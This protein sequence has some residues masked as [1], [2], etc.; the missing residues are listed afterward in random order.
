MGLCESYV[1]IKTFEV[2]ISKY[3]FSFIIQKY[4]LSFSTKNISDFCHFS[5]V[6]A[7]RAIQTWEEENNCLD[8]ICV[9]F[10]N[11]LNKFHVRLD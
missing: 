11:T 7:M 2:L 10:N 5:W 8:A 6:I 4:Y 9:I 3:F 1:H